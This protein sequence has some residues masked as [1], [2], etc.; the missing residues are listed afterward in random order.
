[1]RVGENDGDLT[2]PFFRRSRRA[3]VDAGEKPEVTDRL[4][5]TQCGRTETGDWRSAPDPPESAGECRE[6]GSPAL[7]AD[8][9]R[10][11]RAV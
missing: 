7:G 3:S 5:E 11:R 2:P 10:G 8:R 6:A 1:M 9:A 4:R